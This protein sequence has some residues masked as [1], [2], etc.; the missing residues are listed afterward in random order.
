MHE[1][2]HKI[3]NRPSKQELSLPPG[4]PN[5]SGFC[6]PDVSLVVGWFACCDRFCSPPPPWVSNPLLLPTPTPFQPGLPNWLGFS[7]PNFSPMGRDALAYLAV[8]LVAP[9]DRFCLLLSTLGVRLYTYPTPFL[10]SHTSFIWSPRLV[11]VWFPS[12]ISVP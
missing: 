6:Y 5:W 1:G 10:P 11:G 9:L 12:P 3:V 4:L 2:M 8:G 7:Y